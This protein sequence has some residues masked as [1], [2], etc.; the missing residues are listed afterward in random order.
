MNKMLNSFEFANFDMKIENT[1]LRVTK[2]SN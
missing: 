2:I 1:C